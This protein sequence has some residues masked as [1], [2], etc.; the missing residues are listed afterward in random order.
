MLRRAS[1]LLALLVLVPVIILVAVQA[2]DRPS[3]RAEGASG[4]AIR[5]ETSERDPADAARVSKARPPAREVTE[6]ERLDALARA[7]IWRRPSTPVSRAYLGAPAHAPRELACRF[8]VSTPGGTTPKFD[9]Q[10]ESGEIVRIKYGPGA[11]IPSEVASTRLLRALG[12]GADEVT[13]I[14]RLRCYGCPL[15]PFVTLHAVDLT[16]TEPLYERVIDYDEA[17]DFEWVAL[18]RKHPARAIESDDVKGWA[19]FELDTV[20][21]AKGGAP[22]AHVDALRL[23]AAFLAHW[24]NKPENQRL[25]CLS[26]DWPEGQPCPQPFLM[27]QDTGAMFGPRK[28]DLDAW[29]RSP[30]WSDRV[31]C[32]VTLAHL[33]YDGATFGRAEITERGRQHLGRLL[34]QLS[35]AQLTQL[36]ASARFDRRSGVFVGSRPVADWV[37][38]FRAKVHEITDGPPCPRR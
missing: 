31:Q 15:E 35:E 38:A 33:P 8:V 6:E 32:A 2:D 17:R 37:A 29:E 1:P 30:I 9:C 11:E 24:D 22:R 36:F 7:R 20:E 25:V 21:S 23:L 5:D 26:R 13:L 18:E 28:V 27:V 14:E 19:F 12:F 4:V 10:L 16:R 3:S 34:V